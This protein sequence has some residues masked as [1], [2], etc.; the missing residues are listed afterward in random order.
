MNQCKAAF[1]TA[2]MTQPKLTIPLDTG[3]APKFT[4]RKVSMNNKEK[5]DTL[6][7]EE[8]RKKSFEELGQLNKPKQSWFYCPIV[9]SAVRLFFL[10]IWGLSWVG[11]R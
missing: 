10:T 3:Y 5:I 6:T 1:N 4:K 8:I 2:F 9:Q 7:E 11:E